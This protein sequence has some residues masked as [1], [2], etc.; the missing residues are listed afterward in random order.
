MA[1]TSLLT[2]GT[3]IEVLSATVSNL[4]KAK[5]LHGKIIV[6]E[7]QI[8]KTLYEI[9]E[10]KGNVLTDWQVVRSSCIADVRDRIFCDTTLGRFTVHLPKDPIEGAEVWIADYADTFATNYIIVNGNGSTISG[11]N[12]NLIVDINSVELRFVYRGST[13]RFW[14]NKMA[15][16]S[17]AQ[18]DQSIRQSPSDSPVTGVAIPAGGSGFI[19]W[20]SAIFSRLNSGP[21]WAASGLTPA[22]QTFTGAGQSAPFTPNAGRPV[23]LEFSGVGVADLQLEVR[24]DG[25]NW[26]PIYAL[27]G[28]TQMYRFPYSGTSMAIFLA[29][30]PTAGASYRINDLAHTSGTVTARLSQ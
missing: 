17:D 8:E 5:A 14:G 6:A 15:S 2:S 7:R 29:E 12:L 4:E 9:N 28:A 25:T 22:S 23:M 21:D 3:D 1:S 27:D 18:Y 16:L 19:G 13:W 20:L 30:L 24:L 11:K 26:R 10:V